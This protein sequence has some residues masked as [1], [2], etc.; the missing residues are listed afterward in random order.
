MRTNHLSLEFGLARVGS[1]TRSKTDRIEFGRSRSRSAVVGTKSWSF[2]VYNGRHRR[3]NITTD[4]WPNVVLFS[5]F[6]TK[7]R[8]EKGEEKA[9][10]FDHN[11]VGRKKKTSFFFVSTRSPPPFGNRNRFLE[12]NLTGPSIHQCPKSA[13][14]EPLNNERKK[15]D[16]DLLLALF[17]FVFFMV[18]HKKKTGENN[19]HLVVRDGPIVSLSSHNF[20]RRVYC[21]D[22]QT[23]PDQIELNNRK[24]Q[25]MGIPLH[26]FLLQFR[27]SS[28]TQL[29]TQ[30]HRKLFFLFIFKISIFMVPFLNLKIRLT[31]MIFFLRSNFVI[32]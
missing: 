20:P 3:G 32:F 10:M 23:E 9:E 13:H 22:L 26:L 24:W 27:R 21:P 17:G 18:Q 28:S 2:S 29:L 31:F 4:G 1:W 6:E 14:T 11:S 15:N 7:T 12:L 8:R 25:W 30:L 19:Q 5:C 16:Y